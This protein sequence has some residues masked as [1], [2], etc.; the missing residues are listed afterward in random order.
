MYLGGVKKCQVLTFK[1]FIIFF[2]L[3]NT[4]LWANVLFF[5]F[6]IT[7]TFKSLY[8]KNGVQFLAARL[9][10]NSKNS[11]ISFGYVDFKGKIFLIL[12]LRTWNSITSIAIAC[13]MQG[14]QN[15]LNFTAEIKVDILGYLRLYVFHQ[16]CKNMGALNPFEKT[17]E[18]RF[19]T[20]HT[21]FLEQGAP[22]SKYYVKTFTIRNFHFILCMRCLQ[23]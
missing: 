11:I 23:E 22:K 3:M 20:I 7:L 5:T 13:M 14:I 10:T 8:Y 16:W 18:F 4:N 9:Y 6:L 2:S 1:V 15:D 12:Y 19:S 17:L 21:L